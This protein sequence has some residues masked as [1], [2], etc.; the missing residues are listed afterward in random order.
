MR[1]K[2]EEATR[3]DDPHGLKV[4]HQRVRMM[5]LRGRPK[6]LNPKPAID[7]DLTCCF[8]RTRRDGLSKVV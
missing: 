1:G 5:S 6:T 3:Q 7:A 8:L 2:G 4:F